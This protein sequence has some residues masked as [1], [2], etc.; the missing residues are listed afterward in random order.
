MLPLLLLASVEMRNM[1]RP[2]Y[3]TLLFCSIVNISEMFFKSV[4]MRILRQFDAFFSFHRGQSGYNVGKGVWQL[5]RTDAESGRK[6][7]L[8][9][10]P[11]GGICFAKT[12]P[13]LIFWPAPF[14]ETAKSLM[15]NETCSYLKYGPY[16]RHKVK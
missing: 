15:K 12:S 1:S 5:E 11:C 3:H 9:T 6:A 16:F 10:V 14:M 7:V 2:C 4:E 13:I 8:M